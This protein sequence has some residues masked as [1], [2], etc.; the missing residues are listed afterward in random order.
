MNHKSILEVVKKHKS[1]V[2]AKRA[3][4]RGWQRIPPPDVRHKTRRLGKE[5]NSRRGNLE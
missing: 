1:H 3:K 2:S 4:S 5:L